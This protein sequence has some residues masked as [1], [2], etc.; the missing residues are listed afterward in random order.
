MPIKKAYRK[1]RAPVKRRAP[2]RRAARRSNVPE[3]ASLSE[4]RSYVVTGGGNPVFNQI[5]SLMN[6]SL[7]QFTRASTVAQAYQ[8]YRIKHICITVK[9]P[10]DTFAAD[11][12]TG[13][14]K[15]YLYYM[16]DKAG[17]IPTNIT[18]EGMKSMGARPRALDEKPLQIKWSPSVLSE[19]TTAGGPAATAQGAAYK[20]SPWLNTSSVSVGSPWNPSSVDHLGVYWRVDSPNFSG[21]PPAYLLEVEV[22]F[23]FKKPLLAGAVGSVSAISILPAMLNSSPDGIVGG[24]DDHLAGPSFLA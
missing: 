4:R 1:K 10:F 20:I 15:P 19:V 22:Q 9:S 5:Y 14:G 17:A 3:H 6:T 21:S 2:K 7:N 16:L 13:Y 18:L 23:Q 11:Q 12:A 24:D 8:H